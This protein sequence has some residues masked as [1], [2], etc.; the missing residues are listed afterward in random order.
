V[1]SSAYR[2]FLIFSL[3]LG[4]YVWLDDRKF[5]DLAP[6]LPS[7]LFLA[8]VWGTVR[9]LM[10]RKLNLQRQRSSRRWLLIQ[11]LT[12][13]SLAIVGVI[14]TLGG[15][16]HATTFYTRGILESGDLSP[17]FMPHDAW[18]EEI[19]VDG[20]TITNEELIARGSSIEELL[21]QV[22]E[23]Y[24]VQR[25]QLKRDHFLQVLTRF[26]E[27]T[28][29][30]Q[31]T[32]SLLDAAQDRLNR[33][34]MEIDRL[35]IRSTAT[36]IIHQILTTQ[37]EWK[38]VALKSEAETMRMRRSSLNQPWVSRGEL[39]GYFHSTRMDDCPLSEVHL[40]VDGSIAEQLH[41]GDPV[42]LSA[43]QT[44]NHVFRG[45]IE[46]LSE[47]PSTLLPEAL[48]GDSLYKSWVTGDRS[49]LNPSRYKVL[50]RFPSGNRRLFRGGL[51]TVAL[52]LKPSTWAS[53]LWNF[54]MPR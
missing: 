18:L 30:A 32:E 1:G 21:K 19:A 22:E 34:K 6:I 51:V 28:Q 35:H 42:Q 15:W 16:R 44:R 12:W 10:T 26:P 45:T 25:L 2:W 54:V 46:R 33:T 36:G 29:S 8:F 49:T 52:S 27:V 3:F 37:W 7:I 17:V 24:E 41:V 43:D 38:R 14:W 48:E 23:E 4:M 20:E 50:V 9:P 40:Y 53:Q 47:E 39:I 31:E 5:R 11:R 13:I